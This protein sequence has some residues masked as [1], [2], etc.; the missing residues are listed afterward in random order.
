MG[1][2]WGAGGIL[3]GSVLLILGLRFVLLRR[4][5]EDDEG[6]ETAP[7]PTRITG[8]RRGGDENEALRDRV[9]N[10]ERRLRELEARDRPRANDPRTDGGRANEEIGTEG[11]SLEELSR[12]VEALE[13]LCGDAKGVAPGPPGPAEAGPRNPGMSGQETALL[14]V[15]NRAFERRP[16]ERSPGGLS[17]GIGLS[18]Q[19]CALR[20]MDRSLQTL[21][22]RHLFLR[23]LRGGGRL[24][25]LRG[26][27][28]G[29]GSA[30]GPFLLPLRRRDDLAA[31]HVR[32]PARDGGRRAPGLRL[33]RVPA[34]ARGRR[35]LP[36]GRT[37]PSLSLGPLEGEPTPLSY[38]ALGG[39]RGGRSL[40]AAVADLE[41]QTAD[42]LRSGGGAAASGLI[43]AMIPSSS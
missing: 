8:E 26:G 31:P 43:S 2:L 10:L 16:G 25:A 12:R 40:A 1:A 28:G 34:R 23:P 13:A 30:G 9:E 41:T 32:W 7:P 36:P 22:G 39:E 29:A 17:L 6:D 42:A 5:A 24:A 14:A 11:A 35:P 15:A 33:P 19:A 20:D 3:L 27:R 18:A 37:G 4:R 38:E 21:L